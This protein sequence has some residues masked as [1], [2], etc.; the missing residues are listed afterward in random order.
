[1]PPAMS[2]ET[3]ARARDM[4]RHFD[5]GNRSQAAELCRTLL[6][7]DSSL[8]EPYLVAGLMARANGATAEAEPFLR[9]ALDLGRHRPAPCA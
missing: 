8:A 4:R 1:M 6:S 7:A 9:R 2:G 5:L 3:V